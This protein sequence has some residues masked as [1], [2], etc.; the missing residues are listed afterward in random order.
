MQAFCIR[1]SLMRDDRRTN[2]YR[3]ELAV[4]LYCM[5]PSFGARRCVEP[6][7]GRA[8]TQIAVSMRRRSQQTGCCF[9]RPRSV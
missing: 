6:R 8:F 5:K 4:S 7:A 1:H 3:D 2:R 9:A